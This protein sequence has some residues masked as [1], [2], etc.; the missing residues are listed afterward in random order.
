[1]KH[2][3]STSPAV[4]LAAGLALLAATGEL[5]AG[6]LVPPAG[7][8]ASTSK[9]LNEIEPRIAINL[10]NTP[11]DADSLF[12]I[13]QPGSYYLAGNITG[14]AAKHG[15]EIG[16]SNVSID[17]NGFQMIGVPTSLDGIAT[18]AIGFEG[19]SIVNGTVRNWGGTGVSAGLSNFGFLVDRIRAIGNGD[20][21]IYGG[22]VSIVTNCT[23]LRNAQIGIYVFQGSTVTDCVA[24]ENGASGFRANVACIFSRCSAW[25]N[26]DNGFLSTSNSCK[27]IDCIATANTNAGISMVISCTVTDCTVTNNG[28]DGIVCTSRGYIARNSCANN[29]TGAGIRVIGSDTRIEENNCTSAA[30]GIRVTSSGCIIL[31]NSCA[32]NGVNW[33]IAANNFYGPIIDRTTALTAS[34]NGNGAGSTLGSSDANANYSY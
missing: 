23:A 33:D 11:G 32:S 20:T 19:I 27:V 3:A 18:S 29:G 13:T 10:V 7:P 24:G 5:F 8:V 6:P 34:V 30:F 21:G 15:I 12:K 28:I 17:L 16:V 2:H 4:L 1:M 31:R 9:P 22:N 26:G 25:D 14:V